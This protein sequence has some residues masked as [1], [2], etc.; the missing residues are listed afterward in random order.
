MTDPTPAAPSTEVDVVIVGGGPAGLS[1]ALNL[2]RARA[3]VVLIDA[4][5]P[6]HPPAPRS[7]RSLPRLVR[8][9][10]GQAPH[11]EAVEHAEHRR[12]ERDEQGDLE[13]DVTG[14]VVDADH[15]VRDL[16]RLVGEELD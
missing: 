5:R 12:E 6:R 8:L 7:P 15:L 4:G 13:R 11:A 9:R 3:S 10:V 14:L 1:A 16:R 2:G